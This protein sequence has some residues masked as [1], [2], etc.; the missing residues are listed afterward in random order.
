M[1]I[2]DQQ[3]KLMSAVLAGFQPDSPNENP[4]WRQLCESLSLD[5]ED[6]PYLRAIFAYIS[7]NDWFR[8]LNEPK[9]S[10]KERVS[11]ALRVLPDD[12]LT[13]YLNKL[14]EQLI[15][16]GDVE[17]VLLTG[18]TGRAVDL[19]EQTVNRY[20]DVQTAS[21]VMSFVVPRHF[22]DKRVEDWIE[23]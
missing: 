3:R 4:T 14:T 23:R 12:S 2:L 19:L 11:V 21:L 15:R 22:K 5:M 16:E 17:G 18:L 9:L 8:V 1:M 6:Q 7:S 13:Q 20:G 10:L